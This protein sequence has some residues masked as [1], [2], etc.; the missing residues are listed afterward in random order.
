MPGGLSVLG[1]PKAMWPTE[2]MQCV[3][4]RPKAMYTVPRDW[5]ESNAKT[6]LIAQPESKL[7]KGRNKIE[8][9][10]LLSKSP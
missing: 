8:W 9:N 1:R 2:R 4:G 6:K 5:T 10:I 7:N 3:L